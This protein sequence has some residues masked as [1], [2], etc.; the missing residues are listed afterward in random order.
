MAKK[1]V[2]FSFHFDNDVWRVQQIRNMGV[3]E[4]NRPVTPNDW[5][6]VKRHG[7]RAIK[8]WIDDNMMYKRCVVVL[9]GLST[10]NR[11]WVK[12]E[13]EKAWAE[14][15]PIVGIY[16]HNLENQNGHTSAKGKNPFE[17]C[18]L[19]GNEWVR[20]IK[21]HEPSSTNTYKD[22]MINIDNWVEQAIY[23]NQMR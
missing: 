9:I 4:D 17:V 6:Q 11:P 3:L 21:C 12:Y 15:K 7:D 23:K 10:A 18:N 16:I 2:F 22:I 19:G 8:K 13:I 5:E 20:Y 14:K 1:S